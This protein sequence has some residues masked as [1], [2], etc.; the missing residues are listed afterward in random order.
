MKLW[1][2]RKI[3]VHDIRTLYN[4]TH[5]G[6]HFERSEESIFETLRSAQGDRARVLICCCLV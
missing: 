2:L 3:K 1:S 6:C 5:K 4:V